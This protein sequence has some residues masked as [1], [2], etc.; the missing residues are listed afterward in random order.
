[1]KTRIALAAAALVG[2]AGTAVAQDTTKIAFID[3]LSGGNAA[4]GEIS[5]NTNRFI[6]DEINAAGGVNGKKLEIVPFD[7]KG[8]PQ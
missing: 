5:L 2:F 8:V 1:M 4:V 7:N 6:A 3:P